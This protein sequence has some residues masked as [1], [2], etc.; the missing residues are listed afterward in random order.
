MGANDDTRLA[1]P[2]DVFL[3]PN[4]SGKKCA[5]SPPTTSSSIHIDRALGPLLDGRLCHGW[6]TPANSTT[7]PNAKFPLH[8]H[9]S[10]QENDSHNSRKSHNSKTREK[11]QSA[12]IGFYLDHSI[13][14]RDAHVMGLQSK[15]GVDCKKQILTIQHTPLS[16]L[17]F[18]PTNMYFT[19]DTWQASHYSPNNPTFKTIQLFEN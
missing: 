8:E 16:V 2:E 14:L 13:W 18:T 7:D 19:P 15:G 3:R 9:L 5:A 10:L 12:S 6:S 4:F 11:T 1:L 17:N